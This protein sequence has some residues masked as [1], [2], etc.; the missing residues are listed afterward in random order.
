[1]SIISQITKY[2]ENSYEQLHDFMKNSYVTLT[3]FGGRRVRAI[4]YKGS[5]AADEL[6]LKVLNLYQ[7][8]KEINI[9]EH[10]LL[11]KVEIKIKKIEKIK[12]DIIKHANLIT[13]FFG[14]L[15]DFVYY[16]IF[17]PSVSDPYDDLYYSMPNPIE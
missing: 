15:R 17:N 9:D 12:D 7:S 10:N 2:N 14:W 11:I 4:G 6:A 8:H 1:M 13:R 16:T 5:I 3:F